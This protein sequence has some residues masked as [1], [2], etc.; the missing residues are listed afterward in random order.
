M[1]D[2]WLFFSSNILVITMAFHTYLC[3]MCKHARLETD[4]Q[5]PKD[6]PFTIPRLFVFRK[7]VCTVCSLIS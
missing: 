4:G 1:L 3:Y 7:Q 2:W 6:L 5:A